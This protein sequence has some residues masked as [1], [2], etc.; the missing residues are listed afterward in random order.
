[1]TSP[2]PDAAIQLGSHCPPTPTTRRSECRK[3]QRTQKQYDENVPQANVGQGERSS[4][5]PEGKNHA[6]GPD[7]KELTA[8]PGDFH[9]DDARDKGRKQNNKRSPDHGFPGYRTRRNGPCGT[10]SSIAVRSPQIIKVVIGKISPDLD[11]Q[12]K[13]NRQ[14]QKKPRQFAR[15]TEGQ[16][17][18]REN[19]NQGSHQGLG[20]R[21]P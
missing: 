3:P 1:M 17:S 4:G 16:G 19:G 20:A 18:P 8:C 21:W 13:K 11:Q 7:P 10:E 15:A 12:G 14:S 2:M 6:Q 5:V 9:E